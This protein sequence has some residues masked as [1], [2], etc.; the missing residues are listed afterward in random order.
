[1]MKCTARPSTGEIRLECEKMKD[2]EEFASMT[3]KI[4][5]AEGFLATVSGRA[6]AKGEQHGQEQQ[7]LKILQIQ[8]GAKGAKHGK[9]RDAYCRES[10]TEPFTFARRLRNLNKDGPSSMM[11]RNT[12]QL[13]GQRPFSVRCHAM[14][15][16][17]HD[18]CQ[19]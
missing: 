6:T 10:G 13:V 15:K 3:L 12:I 9:W 2:A 17:C 4:E 1:M 16:W 18:T 7:S 8:F 19:V 14:S 11:E 5:R